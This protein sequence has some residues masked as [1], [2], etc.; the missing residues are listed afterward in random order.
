MSTLSYEHVSYDTLLNVRPILT[1]F[2]FSDLHWHR[3]IEIIFACRGAVE[4]NVRGEKLTLSQGNIYIVNSEFIHSVNSM[5]ESSDGNAFILQISEQFMRSMHLNINAVRY[6][7]IDENTQ[8]LDEIRYYMFQIITELKESKPLY[9][10]FIQSYCCH[11]I[12]ILSRRHTM[13]ADKEAK[14]MCDFNEANLARIKRVLT[15]LREHYQESPSLVAIAASEYVSPYYL[16][17]I[18]TKI[19]GM[20]YS[21]YINTLKVNMICQDLTATSESI[22]TILLRHGFSNFKTFNRVFRKIAG[23][24]PTEYR[25]LAAGAANAEIFSSFDADLKYG[26]YV[27]FKND[28]VI[29]DGPC[30]NRSSQASS[31]PADVQEVIV[32]VDPDEHAE[33]LDH[34]YSVM[35]AAARAFDLL[36]EDVREQLRIAQREIGFQYARF[37]G[38][39]NDE[40]CVVNLS[41]DGIGFNFS[42]IDKIFDFLLSIGLK[43]FVELSL[44]PTSIASGRGVK[45][46]SD[47]ANVTPLRD[48]KL[49]QNLIGAFM[50]HIILR[51]AKDEVCTWYFEVWNEPDLSTYRGGTFDDYMEL[52]RIAAS[53]IKNAD[54]RF[55]IGG[56]SLNSFQYNDAKSYLELFL[57][58]CW[59]QDLPV[60][61]VS[62]HPYP[63]FCCSVD[64]E[65]K[66][67]LYKV[68]QA[69]KDMQW[70]KDAV[71]A[72]HYPEAEIHLD[73]WNS[74]S[75]GRDLLRDTAFTAAFVL[76]NVVNGISLV[77]SLTYW[78]LSDLT[79]ESFAS[80]HEFHGGFGMLSKSGFRKPAYFAYAYLSRLSDSAI[81]R[82]ENYIATKNEKSIQILA[83]NYCHYREEYA[84]GDREA[85]TFRDR[86]AAF[87]IGEPIRFR[88]RLSL[89]NGDYFGESAIFNREHGS[90]FDNWLKN[91][92]LEYLS[93]KQ[94][95]LI[96]EQTHPARSIEV[97][98]CRDGM[99]ERTA[100]VEPFGFVFYEIN[101][102]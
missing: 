20:N 38:I 77:N 50:K 8:T 68:K 5:C 69:K 71:R 23:C 70:I 15:Y 7:Q 98:E 93:P 89:A 42:Y 54:I 78:T 74:R 18:F 45:R 55:K 99:I 75:L 87:H 82:G 66:E 43:P 67:R 47:K 90:I 27:S 26:N 85:V 14:L 101:L 48:I 32:T 56:P 44:I 72:S 102:E 96:A 24:S 80:A 86:Y 25:R 83:W 31:E 39:F 92:A 49:W 1:N 4:L 94:L 40:M 100:W 65:W 63:A 3:E 12:A 60:D 76:Q 51:Y 28:I 64:G 46:H 58:N 57:Q 84:K 37:H 41:G 59:D 33:Q 2:A 34:Y 16:S 61:F 9:E 21:Q 52:Y 6:D 79:E 35:T 97:Y 13:L 62:G 53:E 11:I 30:N 95:E 17:H 81:S 22:T 73:E 88:F 19:M 91:G 36:R 10:I 29:P